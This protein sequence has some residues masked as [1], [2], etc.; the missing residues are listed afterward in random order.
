[1][2]PTRSVAVTALLLA[3]ST[4]ASAQSLFATRG[5][6]VPA[7]AIDARAAALGGIGLGLIGFH[8]TMTNP[9]EVAGVSRRGVAAALQPV[10]STSSADGEEDGTSGTRFPLFRVIYP[11]SERVV[12]SVGYGSY[13]E[14]SWAVVNEVEVI[15]NGR[16]INAADLLRSAG[17]I[18]QLQ[19]G[20]AYSLTP[21]LSLG[22]AAGVLTGNL[23]RTAV[24][25]YNDTTTTDPILLRPFQERLRWRYFAPIAAVGARLDIGGV[26]RLSGSALAGGDLKAYAQEGDAEDRTYGAPLELSAGASARV[27]PLLMATAGGAWSRL[28]D[29]GEDAVSRETLRFGAGVEYQGVGSGARTYPVRLGARWAQLPYHFADESAPTETALGL[30]LGFVLGDPADPAAVADIALERGFRNGLDGGA[31]AGGVEERLWRFT[32]SLSL[33]GR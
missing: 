2:I 13:L 9:A 32:F 30:G 14:Q 33:F 5:L 16:T 22:V 28:P 10:S 18:A 21:T 3:L 19:V 1:M 25:S 23:D 8:T 20:V 15:V 17:G 12:G 26:V 11:L 7:P 6:G 4:P 29:A 24:R 31:V 27:S